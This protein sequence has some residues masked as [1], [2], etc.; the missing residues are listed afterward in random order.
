[1]IIELTD[2]QAQYIGGLIFNEIL[3]RHTTPL[4]DIMKRQVELSETNDIDNAEYKTLGEEYQREIDHLAKLNVLVKLFRSSS[5]D[6]D[7]LVEA[8]ETNEVKESA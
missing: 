7:W 5:N 1:M 8:Q 4:L 3:R 6:V 2:S